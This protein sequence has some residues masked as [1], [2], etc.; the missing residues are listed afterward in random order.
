M[1]IANSNQER[2]PLNAAI[3]QELL[4]HGAENQSIKDIGFLTAALPGGLRLSL[5]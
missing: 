1:I 4:S 3:P 5:S 2:A